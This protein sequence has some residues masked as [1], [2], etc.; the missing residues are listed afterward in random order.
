MRAVARPETASM[1]RRIGAPPVAGLHRFRE[2]G[3]VDDAGVGAER[4][5]LGE[6]RGAPHHVQRAQPARPREADEQAAD[7]GVGDVLDH[8]VTRLQVDDVG[9][10]ARAPWAD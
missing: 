3:P 10:A 7:G 6:E 2:V 4:L 1:P 9:R 5:E 8:P